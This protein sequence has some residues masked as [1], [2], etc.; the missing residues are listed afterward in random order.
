MEATPPATPRHSMK[1]Q[2]VEMDSVHASMLRIN[3]GLTGQ[4]FQT[5]GA[6]PYL[7]VR[8][9]RMDAQGLGCGWHCHTLL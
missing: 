5:D 6:V 4:G 7:P 9:P 8:T 3:A 1:A 2:P